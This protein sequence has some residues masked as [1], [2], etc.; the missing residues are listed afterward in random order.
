[1]R[2]DAAAP[3]PT[4]RLV[5]HFVCIGHCDPLEE[6]HQEVHQPESSSTTRYKAR[7]LSQYPSAP[8]LC[9]SQPALVSFCLP[10]GLELVETEERPEDT[11]ACYLLTDA[12]GQR[13][14]GHCLTTHVRLAGRGLG[15][16]GLV[17]RDGRTRVKLGSQNGG[18]DGGWRENG[19]VASGAQ[20][21]V[22]EGATEGRD[23]SGVIV[24][25]CLVEDSLVE[26]SLVED[27]LVE[28]SHLTPPTVWAPCC[29]CLLSHTHRP[30]AFRSALSPI[31]YAAATVRGGG[32]GVSRRSSPSRDG[33]DAPARRGPC[34]GRRRSHGALPAMARRA[35]AP[36][37]LRTQGLSLSARLL[38]CGA[39][40]SAEATRPRARMAVSAHCKSPRVSGST[41]LVIYSTHTCISEFV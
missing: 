8:D 34:A 33:R 26:D 12:H 3:Q 9:A 40:M 15:G 27:S 5:E 7:I 11:F 30:L 14:Y 39:P 20:E 37:V 36:R 24:E 31:S 4:E 38:S 23:V 6:V 18:R 19:R 2:P 25:D 13:V 35:G 29:L 17:G 10:R 1:M 28:E 22:E 32:G 21:A 16:R 41:A